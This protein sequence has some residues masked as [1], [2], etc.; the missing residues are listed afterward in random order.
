VPFYPANPNKNPIEEMTKNP[1]LFDYQMYFQDEGIAEKEFEADIEYT[2][3]C[4][5]RSPRDEDKLHLSE[6][7][8]LGNVRQRGGMLV[9]YPKNVKKSVIL[10]DYDLQQ[11]LVAFTQSGFRGGL[12][13]YRN[14]ENNWKWNCK[15]AGQKVQVPTLMVT[16]GRDKLFPPRLSEHMDKWVPNLTKEHIHHSGHWVMQEAPEELN[17]ILIGWLKSLDVT[18]SSGAVIPKSNL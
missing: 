8:N 17:K 13:W 11:Y 6:P 9:G 10:S 7:I 4:I 15:C 12:N 3:K 5:M 18:N 14:V 1:G 16:V 2:M